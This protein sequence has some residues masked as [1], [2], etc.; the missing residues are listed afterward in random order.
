MCLTCHFGTKGAVVDLC[1]CRSLTAAMAASG[2][3]VDND[4]E[5]AERYQQMVF[6]VHGFM[7]VA[8]TR[9]EL[10]IMFAQRFE[11]VAGQCRDLERWHRD[12][13][14]LKSIERE[15]LTECINKKRRLNS[16][17]GA[18]AKTSPKIEAAAASCK[19]EATTIPG[20]PKNEAA[21]T[22][23]PTHIESP[24]LPPEVDL[25]AARQYEEDSQI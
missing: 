4:K 23:T 17:P 16:L 10:L 2:T 9:P 15:Q 12:E 22:G 8:K 13:Q 19:S 1:V 5:L 18:G 20:V 21:T 7:R 6:A 24:S 25:S 3:Y 11:H 14:M